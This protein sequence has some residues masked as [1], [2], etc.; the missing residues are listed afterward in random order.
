MQSHPAVAQRALTTRD[1]RY[2]ALLSICFQSERNC[3]D[4]SCWRS[5]HRR[6]GQHSA[7]RAPAAPDTRTSRHCHATAHSRSIVVRIQA[8]GRIFVHESN[9]H[10]GKSLIFL[11][12]LTWHGSCFSCEETFFLQA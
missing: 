8:S 2:E 5:R 10:T 7:V 9:I 4:P 12:A 3:A 1:G 11:M 6:A